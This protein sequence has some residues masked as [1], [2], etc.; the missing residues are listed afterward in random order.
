MGVVDIAEMAS[1]VAAE[2]ARYLDKMLEEGERASQAYLKK[3]AG[4]FGGLSVSCVID[5]GRAAEAI[6]ERAA[7]D[8]GT[9][10]AM[11]THGRSGINRWMLG[12]VAEKVLRAT[13]NPLLLIRAA[14][15]AK[16]DEEA[17]L[18]SVIVPLDGSELAESVLPAVVELAK[19]L[20][21]EIVLFRAFNIPYGI[22]AGAD[23]YY[24]INFDQLIAEMR[25][26]A[27]GYLEKKSEELKN[28]GVEKV[29]FLTKEGLSADEI[30]SFGRE[31]PDNLIA[32]C[33]HGRSG[34]RRWVLGSVTETVVRHCGDP[35]LVI[36]AGQ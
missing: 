12:S 1:H 33:T 36:R 35:V 26:E 6:I 14:E 23:G 21:L 8:N 7:A 24:A 10:I 15:Q 30:I 22:Y 32:M 5:K 2:N 29:S 20:G 9:L 31:T 3:I 19:K 34:V 13:D 27:A 4:T 28:K 17:R 18:S 16:A 11:A 25:S